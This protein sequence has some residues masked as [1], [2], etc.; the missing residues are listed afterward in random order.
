V[1][2]WYFFHAAGTFGSFSHLPARGSFGIG[3]KAEDGT[4]TKLSSSDKVI[5]VAEN[6]CLIEQRLQL[7]LVI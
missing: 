2:S 3:V 6:L 4:A 7:I 5:N 1:K